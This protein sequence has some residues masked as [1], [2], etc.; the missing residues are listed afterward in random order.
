MNTSDLLEQLLR[1]AG[2]G[3]MPQQ[4]GRGASAQGGLGDLGGLLGGLLGG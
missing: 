4:G 3:A 1:G 2:Q